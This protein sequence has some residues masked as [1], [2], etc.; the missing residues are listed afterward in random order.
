M[1]AQTVYNLPA[2]ISYQDPNLKYLTAESNNLNNPDLLVL[3][4]RNSHTTLGV[5]N[6]VIVFRLLLQILPHRE[7][8]P[9]RVS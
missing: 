8:D 2:S 7:H 5:Y 4:I 6:S 3:R 1:D 9:Y